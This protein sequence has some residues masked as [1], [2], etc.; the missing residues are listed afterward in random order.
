MSASF[1]IGA[2]FGMV[3]GLLWLGDGPAVMS[4]DVALAALKVGLLFLAI[5]WL[6]TVTIRL[7]RRGRP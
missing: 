3:A 4:P 5:A 6:A 1:G 7:S 2:G